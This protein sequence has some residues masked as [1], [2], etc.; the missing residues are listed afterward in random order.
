MY[1]ACPH[2]SHWCF[3]LD[4]GTDTWASRRP[5]GC[6]KMAFVGIDM[7]MVRDVVFVV[8]V[9]VV[10]VVFVEVM[11]KGWRWDG[12]GGGDGEESV[13]DCGAGWSCTNQALL[14]TIIRP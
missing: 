9:F 2:D 4:M 8:F 11:V 7:G 3:A 1:V 10:M 6:V 13:V 14:A 5:M 12:D